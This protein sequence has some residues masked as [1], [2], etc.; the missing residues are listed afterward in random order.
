MIPIVGILLLTALTIAFVVFRFAP[1]M[2]ERN[3]VFED[4]PEP[5]RP[6]GYKMAW[7]AVKTEATSDVVAALDLV[8]PVPANWNSGIGAAYDD[9]LSETH[10]F[11]SPPVDGWTF[12]IGLALPHPV[13][14]SF[15]DKLTPLL[16]SMTG[17]FPDAQYYFTYPL[18]DFFAWARVKNGRLVRAFAAGDEGVVWN[19]GRPTREER[20]LGLKLF[21][22]RG[23]QE[24]KGDAGG[25]LLL[26]PTEDHVLQV[27][28]H[29]S[30]DPTRLTD[31]DASAGL[32]VIGRAPASWRAE[33]VRRRAA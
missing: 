20:A 27:A 25:E 7:L 18:I 8:D 2:H 31:S 28:R 26:H 5:P 22:L 32:G 19:K 30:I 6:F 29:W 23:V 21:E 17:R 16:L 15:V 9:T 33:R 24:R 4:A 10:I 13:S 3:L 11:V 12:V 1:R 14:K